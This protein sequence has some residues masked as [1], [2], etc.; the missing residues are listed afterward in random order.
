MA[1]PAAPAGRK[2]LLEVIRD[3]LVVGPDP[4][5][6][7]P[8]NSSRRGAG[9]AG[10]PV[11]D[12][13]AMRLSAFWACARLVASTIGSLPL[14]VYR[15]DA[16]G[17]R[18]SARDA[19]LFRVLHDSPNEDQTP[20]DYWEQAALS[21][22][23]R[24]DHFA[25]KIRDGN[26]LIALEPI[27]PARMTVTRARNGAI[28]YR[29]SDGADSFD[30]GDEDVFH[31]RGFGGGPLRGLSIVAH[32]RTSLGIAIAAD[33]AASALFANG[34]N[35]SGVFSTDTQLDRTQA[36][37]AQELLAEKYQGARRAGL[38]MVI[39]HGLKWQPITMNA[40]DAQLLESRAWSV[41]DIC[42]W[43]GV[44]P[45]M[46]GH[47]EKSTSWGTGIE[48]QTLGFLKF[49]LNPY[50][51][52]IEQAV[53]KQLITPAERGQ[54]LFAEFNIEGLLRADS[55]GRARFY[56]S[57][58]R[59]KWMVVN[60]VRGKENLAPVEWGNEPIVQAQDIPLSEQIETLR[61]GAA[62]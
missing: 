6:R 1:V 24:G 56:E 54:G 3:W 47:S 55:Q 28:R 17:V 32:A 52:R 7:D 15:L 25:S 16:G 44:P 11:N 26:R 62:G 41:E 58:L 9:E 33:T 35:S 51:R 34:I 21:M 38:P 36:S 12:A 23:L 22:M 40:D 13:A 42:R 31:V 30:Q 61:E 60:E 19:P 46:I 27:N 8:R 59:N 37:E 29:W 20:V 49:T 50:L 5:V 14:P 39:G 4:K 18:T 10:V 53:R 43:F 57:A 2:S 48:Q 45:F